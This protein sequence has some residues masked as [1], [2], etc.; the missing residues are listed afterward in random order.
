[1]VMTRF[2]D[3]NIAFE[4]QHKGLLASPDCNVKIGTRDV[5]PYSLYGGAELIYSRVR[6]QLYLKFSP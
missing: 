5:I 4:Q 6:V 2:S 1:M 3:E